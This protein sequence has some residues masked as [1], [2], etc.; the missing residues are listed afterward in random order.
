MGQ[1]LY[2]QQEWQKADC[3]AL[4]KDLEEKTQLSCSVPNVVSFLFREAGL[5]KCRVKDCE[6][7]LPEARRYK[8]PR[9]GGMGL[10]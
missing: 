3:R 4:Q 2:K 10:F 6:E 5:L 7:D 8:A 1:N 9:L